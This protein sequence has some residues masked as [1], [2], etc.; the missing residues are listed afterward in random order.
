MAEHAAPVLSVVMTVRDAE[1]FVAEAVES[2]LAQSFGDFEF[3]VYDNESRDDTAAIVSAYVERD[4]RVMLHSRP[5]ANLAQR[6]REGVAQARGEFVARMDAD[7][8]ARP[9]RFVLQLAWLREHPECVAVGS[10][11]L[12]VDPQRRPIR[13]AGVPTHHEAIVEQLLAGH[14]T[15]L[16]HPAVMLRREAVV[17]AGSY[18]VDH[19]YAEDIDLFLR[20][21]R[22]GHLAN[23]ADILLEYRQHSGAVTSQR[24][25][26]QR[27]SLEGLLR[28]ERSERGLEALAAPLLASAP[29]SQVERW[30]AWARGAIGGGH[31]GTARHYAWAVVRA[32]PI[33][34]RSWRLLG[35]ALLGI[36]L[37]WVRQWLC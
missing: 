37:G 34:W 11:V 22:R 1:R 26:E 5:H 33:R 7:D 6:L 19:P 9:E 23:L 29:E 24:I 13:C 25:A 4:P 35:R 16:P 8:V 32:A 21:A 20:L 27:R 30:E 28:R 10:D 12:L 2:V 3:L 18:R 15:A 17:S 31:R 14:G 36:R